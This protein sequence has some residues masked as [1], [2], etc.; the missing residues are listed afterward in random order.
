M[1]PPPP[2]GKGSGGGLP[3]LPIELSGEQGVQRGSPVPCPAPG[4]GKGL[5]LHLGLGGDNPMLVGS[6]VAIP[7]SPSLSRGSGKGGKGEG[8]PRPPPP[9]AAALGWEPVQVGGSFGPGKNVPEKVWPPSC[10]PKTKEAA[11]HCWKSRARA[12]LPCYHPITRRP[13]GCPAPHPPGSRYG[14]RTASARAALRGGM[15]SALRGWGGSRGGAVMA[16]AAP[17]SPCDSPGP[18]HHH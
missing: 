5:A 3:Q 8:W 17:G 7:A 14:M 6:P 13:R 9:P 2:L 12:V 15:F 4:A 10:F 11:L 18:G 16:P 1:F